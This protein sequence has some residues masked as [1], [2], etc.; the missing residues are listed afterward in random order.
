M[1]VLPTA[2]EPEDDGVNTNVATKLALL[3]NTGVGARVKELKLT[4]PLHVQM[5][6]TL[7]GP[8]ASPAVAS[9]REEAVAGQTEPQ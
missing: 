4:G 1:M 7:E 3:T 5:S 2:S 9:V 6:T 8:P